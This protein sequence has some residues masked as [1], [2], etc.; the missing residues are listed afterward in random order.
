MS[1]F[2][3]IV[4][5]SH[6]LLNDFIFF[7]FYELAMKCSVLFSLIERQLRRG[8]ESVSVC[9]AQWMGVGCKSIVK[10]KLFFNSLNNSRRD[11]FQLFIS[12]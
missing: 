7:L 11:I 3:D 9:Y 5:C 2:K 6:V 12:D 8:V 1:V 4:N 10:V